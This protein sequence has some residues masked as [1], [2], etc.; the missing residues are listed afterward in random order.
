[1]ASF[2]RVEQEG[3]EEIPNDPHGE[4]LK[5]FRYFF[6]MRRCGFNVEPPLVPCCQFFDP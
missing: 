3:K 5:E 2:N 1:M 6:L 4:T